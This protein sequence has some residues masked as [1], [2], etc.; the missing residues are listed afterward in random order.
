MSATETDTYSAQD[1]PEFAPAQFVRWFRE[2]APYVHDFR[3]KTF[4]VAFGGELIE[5]NGLEALVA[6]LSL[7]SALGVKLVLVHGSRP[8]V[9]E[10]LRL[11]GYTTQFGRGTETT[12]PEA[13]ECAKEAAGEIR[14][15]IEAAFSQGLPNTP[16]SHAK[17]R[18]MSGNF[19]TAR[20][21]GV[22]DGVDYRRAGTVRKLD[23]DAMH[24]VISQGAIVLLSP[25]GFSPTGEAFNLAMEDLATN[26][27]VAL[28]AEK[29]IFLTQNRT[30]TEM[31]GSVDTELARKDADDLLAQNILDEDTTAFLRHA[32]LAVKRG[33]ARAHLVPYTLDGSILL[34]IF[35][36]D[37]V[38]TM[39]VEDTL[40]DLRPAMA[41]DVGAIVQL[42]EP[43]EADGTLVPRGRAVIERDVERFTVLE[44]DGVIYGCVSVIPYAKD[45]MAEM[46]CLIV[47]P[48]WQGT[49]D[50]EK[51]LRHAEASA[52]SLG[53]K[54]LFVLTTRTSHWF[55][56]RGFV[57]GG[58][59]D[60]PYEKRAHYNHSRNSLIFI[61]RL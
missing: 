11:K 2:V 37:G 6:D 13:L 30:V 27:A 33:V 39:V 19:V 42:I 10:Q 44:H 20:P 15:D 9:N 49:G 58:V 12:T 47:H 40:E 25:L 53:A 3:G 48:E 54:R 24:N 52:R 5:D 57:Q 7:L 51:L 50:G 17:I 28:R 18:V 32:S 36:H 16:M 4:V 55:L 46:A 26:A 21:V 45:S 38:G 43:L 8:Q 29:L 34:E 23:I 35:T 60:L 41:D 22:I 14:L 1:A 31:D 61:K 56:K 59:S